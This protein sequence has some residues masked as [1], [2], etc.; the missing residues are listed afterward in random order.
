MGIPDY[1][2]HLLRNL[3]EGQEE[4]V[5]T[6]HGTMYWFKTAKR[7]YQGC[8]LSPILFNWYAEYIM[9]NARLDESL[10]RLKISGRNTNNL[11]YADDIT[12]TAES[13]EELKSLLMKVKEE[14]E[15]TGWKLN[16]QKTFTLLLFSPLSLIK[17]LMATSHWCTIS[18]LLTVTCRNFPCVTLTSYG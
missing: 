2:T 14:S 3:H 4:T 9:Q 8:M 17:C 5:R 7:V 18:W 15:K 10:T 6:L 13:K 11:R 1:L 12:L 16:S